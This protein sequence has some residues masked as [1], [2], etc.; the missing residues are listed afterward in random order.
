[1]PVAALALLF[2]CFY[3][4]REWEKVVFVGIFWKLSSPFD[5][6]TSPITFT[7]LSFKIL[8]FFMLFIKV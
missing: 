8:K 3:S 6:L 4:V 5:N 2:A 7:E 1:M